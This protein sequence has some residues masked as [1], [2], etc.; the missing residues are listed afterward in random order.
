LGDWLFRLAPGRASAWFSALALWGQQ[1]LQRRM[2]R[3]R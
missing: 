1:Q 2:A 3:K